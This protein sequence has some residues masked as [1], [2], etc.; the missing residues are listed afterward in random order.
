MNGNI[1]DK[2]L[3]TLGVERLKPF[4]PTAYYDSHMDCIRIEL[5]DSSFTEVRLN[6]HV[7][8]LEDNYPGENRTA[9]AG[10]ML[11]D[12]KHFFATKGLSMDGIVYVTKIL[13]E[14][15]AQYPSLAELEILKLV[16]QLDLTV[17]MSESE[18]I[19]A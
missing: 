11:K 15:V 18:A 6:E 12:V 3:Q 5:R 9:V 2:I 8:F 10:L 7:T 17:D 16:N 19:P 4:K 13:N 14:M 1:A